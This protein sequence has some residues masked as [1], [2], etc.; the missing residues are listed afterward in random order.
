MSRCGDHS[1]GLDTD[2]SPRTEPDGYDI[3]RYGSKLEPW[4]TVDEFPGV[5]V[6]YLPVH[7]L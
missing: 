3:V 7:Y 5:G 6:I 1:A 2:G 4:D